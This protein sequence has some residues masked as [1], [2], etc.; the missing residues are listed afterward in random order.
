MVGTDTIIRKDSD[1]SVE[2][3]ADLLPTA[4]DDDKEAS[5]EGGYAHQKEHRGV[6]KHFKVCG[7]N[8]K[9]YLS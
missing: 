7:K 1:G 3:P 2:M 6:N 9:H 5:L 4:S 8:Y